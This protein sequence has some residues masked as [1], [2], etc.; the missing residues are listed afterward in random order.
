MTRCSFQNIRRLED[1]DFQ[2]AY[3]KPVQFSEDTQMKCCEF[4]RV[5]CFNKQGKVFY[6]NFHAFVTS[7]PNTGQMS[8]QLSD[9]NVFNVILMAIDSTSRLNSIRKAAEVEEVSAARTWRDRYDRKHESRCEHI[10]ERGPTADR[11]AIPGTQ[12]IR[13]NQRHELRSIP[14]DMEE[15]FQLRILDFVRRGR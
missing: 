1:D 15:L 9:P 14:D 5:R 6:V 3:D 7:K 11:L 12:E 10:P 8:T 2:Y 4:V 13:Q